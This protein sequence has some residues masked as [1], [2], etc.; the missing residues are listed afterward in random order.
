[1]AYGDRMTM[2][3]RDFG[4]KVEI[5][6]QRGNF[7]YQGDKKAIIEYQDSPVR[8]VPRGTKAQKKRS[9]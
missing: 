8:N 2:R 1:M 6:L 5:T 3:I 9:K 4:Q 7:V